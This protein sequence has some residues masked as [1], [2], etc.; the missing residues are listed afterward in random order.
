MPACAAGDLGVAVGGVPGPE[1]R[2][3]RAVV[4]IVLVGRPVAFEPVEAPVRLLDRPDP[5]ECLARQ[6]WSL[7][8][9]AAS[10]SASAAAVATTSA[11][12]LGLAALSCRP[13]GRPASRRTG[14]PRA[15]A[16]DWDLSSAGEPQGKDSWC[17]TCHTGVPGPGQRRLIEIAGCAVHR[18]H[19]C[20]R[21]VRRFSGLPGGR[22]CLCC[23]HPCR[24]DNRD[25]RRDGNPEHSGTNPPRSERDDPS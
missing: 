2:D 3:D 17:G 8:V 5:V 22:L 9:V 6:G 24:S 20:D 7:P 12:H 21:L 10:L 19:R 18:D 23:P 25:H 14:E 1:G 13:S 11:S 4:I 15:I 16:G